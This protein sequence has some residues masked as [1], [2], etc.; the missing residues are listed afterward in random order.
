[1]KKLLLALISLS[2]MANTVSSVYLTNSKLSS[3]LKEEVIQAV[4]E[5]F[6]CVDS[7]GL[8]EVETTVRRDVVDQGIIDLFFTTT[9]NAQVTF[10]DNSRTV[11]IVVESIRWAGSNPSVDWTDIT[12]ISSPNFIKCE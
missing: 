8:H 5:K 9:F 7:Y 3:D 12:D 1:M 4:T 6:P 11:S 2:T 10:S